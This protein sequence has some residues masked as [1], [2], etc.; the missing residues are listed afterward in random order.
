MMLE[1]I[2]RFL[3]PFFQLPPIQSQPGLGVL[4]FNQLANPSGPI[5]Q[6]DEFGFLLNPDLG[7]ATEQPFTRRPTY[8][9]F[10]R[11]FLP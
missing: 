11:R 7:G 2:D 8:C 10:C 9:L 1:P 5:G 6:D 3:Y 4:A